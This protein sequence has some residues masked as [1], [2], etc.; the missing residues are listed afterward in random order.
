MG[1][2]L[3]VGY[4][5][6]GSPRGGVRRYGLE[7]AAA[8]RQDPSLA[9]VEDDCGGSRRS[10]GDL[11]RSARHLDAADVAHLQWKLADWGG[12]YRALAALE[13]F[14][15]ASRKPH[16]VTLHDVY[17]RVGWRE[18]WTSPGALALRRLALSRATV[19]VHGQEERERL[20]GL[21][22]DRVHVVPHFVEERAPLPDRD[23]AKRA[24]GVSG[25]RTITLLGHV[26]RRKGHR[27]VLD[28]LP[29]LPADV[30]ALFAGS[31]IEGRDARARELEA[32]AADLG[33]ADR[34]RFLGFVPDEDLDTV[35]AATDLALC[36]FRDMSASGALSTWISTGRPILASDLPAFR[37]YDALE[38]GAIRRFSPYTPE[39]LAEA[40]AG[41]LAEGRPAIDPL[42]RQLSAALATPRTIERY[43]DVYAAVVS[44]ASPARRR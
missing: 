1:D 20:A 6:L 16:V 22:G 27:L 14:L 17:A 41:A 34:V 42:V 8:A 32:R 5:H 23:L 10:P 9:V 44:A 30:V 31:P 4:L 28:A 38:A 21:I 43:R 12:G 15:Q 18:R 29:L 11:R 26:V 37:E 24:L 25:Y 40:V 19:V 33:V 7:L 39:A 36:P 2:R 3:T 35:L 13:L